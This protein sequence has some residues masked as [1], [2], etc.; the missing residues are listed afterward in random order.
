MTSP[1]SSIEITEPKPGTFQLVVH[2]DGR[3]FDCGNY[4]SRLAAM[5]AGK[6]LIQRKEGEQGGRKKK[7]RGKG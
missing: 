3:R 4:I 6:L 5:T 2:Y 1:D 7:A